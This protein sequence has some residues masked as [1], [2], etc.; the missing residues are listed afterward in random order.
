MCLCDS[1]FEMPDC[2]EPKRVEFFK[3][4]KLQKWNSPN[5]KKFF[6]FFLKDA[7]THNIIT[8]HLF[9]VLFPSVFFIAIISVFYRILILMF[10]FSFVFRLKTNTNFGELYYNN[11]CLIAVHKKQTDKYIKVEKKK[12][13]WEKIMVS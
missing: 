5:L 4:K 11:E 9:L 7:V 2:E 8:S 12:T 10:I 1:Q 3:S 13:D 6:F